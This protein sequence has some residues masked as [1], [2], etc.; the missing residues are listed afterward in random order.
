MRRIR[1]LLGVV[2]ITLLGGWLGLLIGGRAHVAVGPLETT[3]SLRPSLVGGAVVDIP[4]LG[5]VKVGTHRGPL[6]VNVTI[7]QVNVDDARRIF[8]DP[9]TLDALTVRVPADLS[10]GLAV[11]AARG[12]LAGTAGAALLGWLALRPRRRGFATGG[13]A[14]A[15]L[16]ANGA[17]AWTTLDTTAIR[18]P[19]YTGLLA[20][21]PALL[22]D[23]ETIASNL[24]DYREG[25]A[26]LVTNVSKLYDVTSALPAYAPTNEVTRVL[27]ISDLHDNPTSWP[28]IK[29]VV[30]Q[31]DVDVVVDT[32]DIVHQGSALENSYVDGISTLPVPYVYVRGNHD[33]PTTEQ[34]V[35]AQANAVVLD[36]DVQTVAGLTFVGV[37]DPRFTPDKTQTGPDRA[38]AAAADRVA[39]PLRAEDRRIDIAVMHNPD[40]A[41]EFDGLAPYILCG[42]MHVRDREIL[43]DGSWLFQ[44][45]STGGAGINALKNEEP[46]PVTLTVFYFDSDTQKLEAW[47]DITLGGLGLTSA[48][49]DRHLAATFGDPDGADGVDGADESVGGASPAARPVEP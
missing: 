32:G 11:L 21:A 31:F 5:T 17:I 2:L 27:H 42:H 6:A 37:G 3:M 34:A 26:A 19:R 20:N 23:A 1:R 47:D 8:S 33:S 48:T 39:E 36:G 28:V 49:I 7:D 29:S 24:D 4:P 25:L 9:R 14:L 15:I 16:L 43:P 38:E 12:L 44:Q 35:A 46:T 45:G 18:E 30:E 22:G 10:H 13:L 41:R 40:G